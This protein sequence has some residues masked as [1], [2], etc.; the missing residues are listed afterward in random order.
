MTKIG[1]YEGPSQTSTAMD[2]IK[3]WVSG[4]IENSSSDATEL[5][6]VH[7]ISEGRYPSKGGQM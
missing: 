6:P 7:T 3:P 4:D 2:Y 1:D 5:A